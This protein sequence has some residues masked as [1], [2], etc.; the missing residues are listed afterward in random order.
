[1]RPPQQ[2]GLSKVTLAVQSEG[3]HPSAAV[4]EVAFVFEAE[5]RW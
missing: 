2:L 1:M 4:R 3:F 5:I